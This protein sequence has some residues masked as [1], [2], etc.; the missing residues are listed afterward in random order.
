MFTS[1]ANRLGWQFAVRTTK[2]L[3]TEFCA[4]PQIPHADDF[5]NRELFGIAHLKPDQPPTECCPYTPD[6]PFPT[7]VVVQCEACEAWIPLPDKIARTRRHI[8]VRFTCDQAGRCCARA[9][10]VQP[11]AADAARRTATEKGAPQGSAHAGA[12]PAPEAAECKVEAAMYAGAAGSASAVT[13]AASTPPAGPAASCSSIAS[14]ES[15]VG[16][17]APAKV[18]HDSE[19][20]KPPQHGGPEQPAGAP[21]T[22]FSC[23]SEAAF[24]HDP[25]AA[26]VQPHRV[27]PALEMAPPDAARPPRVEPVP[28]PLPSPPHADEEEGGGEDPLPTHPEPSVA[29][30]PLS[31]PTEP[32]APLPQQ[33]AQ[34]VQAGMEE[35]GGPPHAE[36]EDG[37]GEDP[38][39]TQGPTKTS[40]WSA[41]RPQEPQAS[42]VVAGP[43]TGAE[44]EGSPTPPRVPSLPA[45][46]EQQAV[47]AGGGGAERSG[48]PQSV[49]GGG[50]DGALPRKPKVARTKQGAKARAGP[51]GP[52]TL[53]AWYEESADQ[54]A[55]DLLGSFG[56]LLRKPAEVV[57]QMRPCGPDPAKLGDGLL[58]LP[59][60]VHRGPGGNDAHAADRSVLFFTV[61][62]LFAN[63]N[64]EQRAEAKKIGEYDP[65]A[66]IHAG[67]L[68]S[69]AGRLLS[70]PEEEA[71]LDAYDDIGFRLR[72][73]GHGEKVRFKDTA[74]ASGS[75]RKGKQPGD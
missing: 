11:A 75:R 35:E 38:P 4:E 15:G 17:T 10:A 30:P 50:G 72:D 48:G 64:T 62:P 56:D 54:F 31:G 21:T 34:A 40:A 65:D 53:N 74:A 43:L 14:S 16:E 22:A 27:P 3:M 7:G 66:Q 26:L 2:I 49:D 24:S 6:A 20:E 19:P 12:A 71:V 52:D 28:S 36:E 18:M 37:G 51:K 47:A 1:L 32:P 44:E 33:Q 59:T 29:P 25:R 23:F 45:A 61:V 68:L 9:A 63:D 55:R 46:S 70:E 67:W 42:M 5:C 13:A 73:F 60:L 69:Y 58:A 8:G 41:P 57:D 39:P